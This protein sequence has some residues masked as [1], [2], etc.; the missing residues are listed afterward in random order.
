VVVV[1]AVAA[2]TT[3]IGMFTQSRRES[4]RDAPAGLPAIQPDSKPQPTDTARQLAGCYGTERASLGSLFGELTLGRVEPQPELPPPEKLGLGISFVM[5]GQRIDGV[6]ILIP[7]QD[8]C[9]PLEHRLTA[10]WGPPDESSAHRAWWQDRD[11]V[12]VFDGENTAGSACTLR[13]DRRVAPETWLS[14]SRESVVPIWAIGRAAVDLEVVLAPLHAESQNDE[15]DKERVSIQWEDASI[16]GNL[17]R[18]TAHIRRRRVIG[19]EVM[20]EEHVA[21]ES[22]W[23]R[24]KAMFGAPDS[25]LKDR[26]GMDHWRWRGK[27]GIEA[28]QFHGDCISGC[29]IS[30]SPSQSSGGPTFILFGRG[31]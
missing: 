13:F 10:T 29:P 27:L 6:K 21:L 22:V 5:N 17:V 1:V 23:S 8:L 12:A 14:W 20:L 7:D 11:R 30:K 16:D 15:N 31:S 24:I 28:R 25:A 9:M 26:D 3:G 18:L 19:I 4:R 2:I